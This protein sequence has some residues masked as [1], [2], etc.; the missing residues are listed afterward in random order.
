MHAL[1]NVVIMGDL[2]VDAFKS[3]DPQ[4]CQVQEYMHTLDTPCASMLNVIDPYDLGPTTD[5]GTAL[6]HI[7]TNASPKSASIHSV[8]YSYHEFVTAELLPLNME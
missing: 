3:T 2:N 7:W 5:G 1:N 8:Y 6:D 4:Y